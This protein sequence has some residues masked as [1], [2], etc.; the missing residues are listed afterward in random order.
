M[1]HITVSPSHHFSPV[2]CNKDAA[3][4]MQQKVDTLHTMMEKELTYSCCDYLNND[5]CDEDIHD[6]YTATIS[7][8][9]TSDDR[10]KI[11][12]WCYGLVHRFQLDRD[13]V[14]MAMN[15]VIHANCPVV[16]SLHISVIKKSCMIA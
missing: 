8:M 7:Y 5:D 15:L 11:V 1:A 6:E 4:L 13:Y 2:H 14:A 12:D 3:G 16:G 9:V 10:A